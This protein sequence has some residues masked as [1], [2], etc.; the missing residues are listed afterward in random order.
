MLQVHIGMTMNLMD[1]YIQ[2]VSSYSALACSHGRVLEDDGP[3]RL[4]DC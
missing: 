4:Q 2:L 3:Q 1:V